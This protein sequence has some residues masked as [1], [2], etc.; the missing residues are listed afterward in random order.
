MSWFYHYVKEALADEYDFYLQNSYTKPCGFFCKGG[1]DSIAIP[2]NRSEEYYL[3]EI[4]S[5]DENPI[6]WLSHPSTEEKNNPEQFEVRDY[7]IKQNEINNDKNIGPEVFAW[8]FV[9]TG[10][11]EQYFLRDCTLQYKHHKKKPEKQKPEVP[12][13][14]ANKKRAL[15]FDSYYKETIQ[16]TIQV[17][18]LSNYNMKEKPDG[19]HSWLTICILEFDKPGT[20]NSHMWFNKQRS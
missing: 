5:I 1:C 20:T 3:C 11:L 4:K 2:K 10:Q 16:K 18:N 14:P 17:L 15:I 12:I 7:W 9:I 13:L 8:A 19:E 6:G